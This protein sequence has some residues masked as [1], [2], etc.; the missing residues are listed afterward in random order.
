[1]QHLRSFLVSCIAFYGTLW[2][3]YVR[4]EKALSYDSRSAW[5]AFGQVGDLGST[6][7]GTTLAG[8]T[9]CPKVNAVTGPG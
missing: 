2:S 5:W 3:I 7:D 6:E 8:D 9:V 1:M 4:V